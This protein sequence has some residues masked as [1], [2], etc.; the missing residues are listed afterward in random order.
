MSSDNDWNRNVGTG[1]GTATPA[2]EHFHGTG[3]AG[4]TLTETWY[5]GFHIPQER[6]NCFAYCWVH[7]NL[8]VVSAGLFVYQGRKS[9][10][11]A[12]ELFEMR[13]FMSIDV[14][15]DGSHIRLPSSFEVEALVPL[16]HLRMRFRD[17]PR[18][19]ALDLELQAVTPPVMRA[20]N[21]HFEQLMH[22]TGTLRLRGTEHAVDCLQIR[23]RSWGE[24]RPEDHA[25]KSPPYTWVTGAF[26]RDFAFN[27]G[28]HDDPRRDPDWG[29]LFTLA[30]EKAFKDGWV[31][32]DGE[33]RRFRHASIITRR[34]PT[35]MQPLRHQISCEDTSGEH[36]EITGEVIAVTPWSGWSNMVCQ[37]GLV[38][39]TCN[40]RK[41]YGE[42]Q[43]CQWNDYVHLMSGRTG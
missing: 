10:H 39:W 21:K 30:P 36:Y 9:Q 40:G 34:D 15:G 13:D 43:D 33:Q 25:V 29:A 23:D 11:L 7:P 1:F 8:K 35:L 27:I 12:C 32:V 28:A 16:E 14:I 17:E 18:A 19:T 5:W 42:V 41:G 20:N 22:V 26:G 2:D 4:D 38:E 6:I 24:L 31:L 37:I 3:P